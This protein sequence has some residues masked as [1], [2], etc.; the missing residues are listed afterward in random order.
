M[1]TATKSDVQAARDWLVDC[2]ADE[3]IVA[4][5]TDGDIVRE[6]DKQYEGGWAA[7]MRD[8]Y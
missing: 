1:N 8:G 2:G 4:D 7:F 3:D 6:V 5:A